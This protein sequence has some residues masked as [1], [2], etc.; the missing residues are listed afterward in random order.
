MIHIVRPALALLAALACFTGALRAEPEVQERWYTMFLAGEHAGWLHTVNTRTPDRVTNLSHFEMTM[1]RAGA[2]LR[3]LIETE[4]V[5]TAK[6]EPVSMRA[7]T[8]LGQS[9]ATASYEFGP[10]G[11]RVTTRAGGDERVSEQPLPPGEWLTP[12][13]VEEFLTAR[14][15]AGAAEAVVY[16]IDPSSGLKPLKITHRDIRRT[17]FEFEGKSVDAYSALVETDAAPGVTSETIYAADGEMLRSTT[18]MGGLNLVMVLSTREAATSATGMP[19]MMT[20]FSVHPDNP[21]AD[22]RDVRV[23]RYRISVPEGTLAD[24]PSAGAQ[25]ATRIDERT[26]EV[27]V[28]SGRGSPDPSAADDPA[29][30]AVSS[31]IRWDDPEIAKLVARVKGNT[32]LEIAES[33][34]EL[35]YRHIKN[36][37]MGVGF[38]SASE[39]CRSRQ[40]DCTEHGVLLA[41]LLR[42]KGIPS[43]VVTGLIY[44]EEFGGDADIFGYHMWAQGLIDVDGVPQ[45]I[46]F[47]GTLPRRMPFDATHIAIASASLAD[48]ELFTSLSSVT[49]FLGRAAIEV[50]SVEHSAAESSR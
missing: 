30:T 8:D 23:A 48:G 47:D 18:S 49:Q 24:I 46:D 40:G 27:E 15:R 22:P 50:L 37:H 17:Q 14:F 29:F 38:A 16:S 25:R 43:R 26:C 42:G 35:V 28:V 5:E 13:E 10:E 33:A 20:S 19:E 3:V 21:I 11:V 9:P 12:A 4:F 2:D 6:G 1:K 39:V 34:R 41:A 7:V 36:K 31:M 44:V 45:W 32:P